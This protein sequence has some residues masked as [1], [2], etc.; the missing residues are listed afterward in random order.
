MIGIFDQLI[1]KKG[2]PEMSKKTAINMQPTEILHKKT[3]FYGMRI[4]PF[5]VT[6]GLILFILSISYPFIASALLFPLAYPMMR[7]GIYWII[8]VPVVLWYGGL[9]G[10]CWWTVAKR[11]RMQAAK[12]ELDRRQQRG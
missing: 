8:W 3:Q 5:T 6:M 2:V 10:I 12:A 1:I 11:R 9:F 4:K 7:E